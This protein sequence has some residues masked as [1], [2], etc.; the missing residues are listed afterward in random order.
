MTGLSYG[1]SQS[2]DMKIQPKV[3]SAIVELKVESQTEASNL[4]CTPKVSGQ[5]GA[6]VAGLVSGALLFNRFG[7]LEIA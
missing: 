2:L 4:C 3:K 7:R 6:N 1:Q 5:Q